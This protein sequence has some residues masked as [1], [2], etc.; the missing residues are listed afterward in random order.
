M[1]AGDVRDRTCKI[2]PWRPH[3]IWCLANKIYLII[4]GYKYRK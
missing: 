3:F 2:S 4:Y 1:V